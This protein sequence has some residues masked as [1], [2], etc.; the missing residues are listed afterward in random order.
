MRVKPLLLIAFAFI[1]A[2][3]SPVA[4]AQTAL[5]QLPIKNPNYVKPFP[6]LRIV[7]NLYYVGTYD[8]AVYLITTPAGNILINTG[9][10]DSTAA[11]RSN[12]ET[13]GFK[14][15]DIKLL[16]ATHG[17][18]DHVGAMA[19]IKKLT[20]ARMFMHEADADLL[21][22]GG[23]QDFRYPQG[24]GTIYEPV[25]VDRRLKEGD[26]VQ[27]GDTELTVMHHPGHTKGA[28]SFSY[29]VREG[30]RSYNVMIVNMAS[31]N[32]GVQVGFMPGFPEI[33]KAYLTTLQRQK[34]LK[35]D[36][37]VSSHAG[38]FNLHEKY[39]PGDP[40]DPKRFVDPDGYQAKIQFYEKLFGAQLKKE[41]EAKAQ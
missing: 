24:R 35:P 28:T 10:N 9:V 33:T 30:G 19:E 17:H 13:L 14:F 31:I 29:T 2:A 32:P 41:Q 27:L 6:P 15:S 4:A 38:H 26:K 21:E 34:Q 5:I 22:S 11:I 20:G 40:Y 36:I 8:L 18:W 23:G 3:G 37:W 25:K 16:L 39:K 1:V 12:I 7:G